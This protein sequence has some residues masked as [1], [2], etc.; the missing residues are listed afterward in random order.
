MQHTFTA[1][2]WEMPSTGAWVFVSLPQDAVEVRVD[3]LD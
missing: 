1:P 3:L 2:L